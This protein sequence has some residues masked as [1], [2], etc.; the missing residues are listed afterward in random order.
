M[1]YY[2]SGKVAL[3]DAAM[4]VIDA[5]FV[6]YNGGFTAGLSAL[7]MIALLDFYKVKPKYEDDA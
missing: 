7:I 5:G 3:T 4:V 1:F 6:L 2:I